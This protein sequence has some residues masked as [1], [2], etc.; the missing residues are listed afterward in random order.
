MAV[1]MN[2]I[3]T[4][5]PPP[6][7]RE[8]FAPAMVALDIDG[9]LLRTGEPVPE[10]TVRAVRRVRAAGHHVVLA[11][12]RSLVG[13][14]P[15]ARQLGMVRGWV[16]ASNGA[17]TARLTPEASVGY[18]LEQVLRFDVGPVVDLALRAL[19]GVRVGV[20]ETGSGYWVNHLF[21]PEQVNGAQRI[22]DRDALKLVPSARVILQGDGVLSMVDR[23][24]ALRVTVNTVTDTWL[25]ITPTGLSKAT[26]LERVRADLG[27]LPED[28][29][30]V[31]DGMND[32]EALAW[33]AY[34]VA[35]AHAPDALKAVADE[36]TGTIDE[37]GA[38]SVLHSL[39]VQ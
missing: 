20:E 19:P 26:A 30:A 35:M 39:L 10:V 4:Q 24:R 21:S 8:N 32:A 5:A 22:V 17:V 13:V 12:G 25:D 18:V 3:A 34:A 37:H 33:A 23:L 7:C 36:V 14:L 1:R 29:V 28:T 2:A 38:A 6:D 27:V 31:G 15:V 11:S 16:V 9:T